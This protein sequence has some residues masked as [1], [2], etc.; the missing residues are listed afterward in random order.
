MNPSE[1][2]VVV[3]CGGAGVHLDG[4][5][6]R[7]SKGLVEVA[8]EPLVVHLLRHFS[9][10]G[11]RRFVLACGRERDRYEA[12]MERLGARSG[13]GFSVSQGDLQG[14]VEVVDTGETT[15]TGERIRRVRDR[16]GGVPWF[17][18]TYSD[19]L[20]TVDL[21]AE[22]RFHEAHGRIATCVAAQLPTRFRI[23][24]MRRGEAEVRSFASRPVIQSGAINGGFYALRQAVFD[25][26]YLGDPESQVFEERVLERLA[27][28]GQLMAYAHDGAWQHFDAE[29]DLQGLATLVAK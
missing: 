11:S 8:G 5:A 16:V 1:I 18:V 2:P 13:G 15:P 27:R 3:L 22:A 7:W 29:R 14:T 21:A 4:S 17:W 28:D 24:G 9:R 10:Y 20:S 25:A 6:R 12:L 19:T 26:P 23:L